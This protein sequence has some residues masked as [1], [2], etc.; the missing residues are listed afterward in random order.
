MSEPL[1]TEE[2]VSGAVLEPR[3]E[4]VVKESVPELQPEEPS[5][6]EAGDSVEELKAPKLPPFKLSNGAREVLEEKLKEEKS[7]VASRKVWIKDTE[8]E[9]A[10]FKELLNSVPEE[11]KLYKQFSNNLKTK[12][13][14]LKSQRERL[15]AN[16]KEVLLLEVA[17]GGK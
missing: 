15:V 8:A 16:E 3:P 13:H 1:P 5:N 6:I 17:L 9:I 2:V 12:E 7:M 11:S 14:Y 4:E 10:N